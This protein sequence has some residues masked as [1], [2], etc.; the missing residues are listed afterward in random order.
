MK[1]TLEKSSWV[2]FFEREQDSGGFSDLGESE[3]DSPDFTLVAKS[4][5]AD[6]LQLLVETLLLE[7][8]TRR[9]VRLRC[10]GR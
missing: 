1:L 10:L 4:E 2:L 6:E 5:F 9:R 3:L 7:G 8:T